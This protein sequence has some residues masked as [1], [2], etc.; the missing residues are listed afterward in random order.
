MSQVDW[1][2]AKM[3]RAQ[4]EDARAAYVIM[5]DAAKVAHRSEKEAYISM[6]NIEEA[7]QKLVAE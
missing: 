6:N 1:A 3:L 5:R 2:T 4:L 7:L